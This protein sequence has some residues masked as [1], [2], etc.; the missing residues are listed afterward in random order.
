M[1][2]YLPKSTSFVPAG[3]DLGVKLLTRVLQRLKLVAN[4][5]ICDFPIRENTK[6]IL[7]LWFATG[8]RKSQIQVS[9][10]VGIVFVSKTTG[11][12]S[13]LFRPSTLMKT[14]WSIPWTTSRILYRETV[15]VCTTPS[16]TLNDVCCWQRHPHGPCAAWRVTSARPRQTSCCTWNEAMRGHFSPV[17]FF[18]DGTSSSVAIFWYY[19]AF[20][21]L[22]GRKSQITNLCLWITNTNEIWECSTIPSPL[23]VSGEAPIGLS[24]K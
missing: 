4:H 12:A 8:G 13:F 23:N 1:S 16:C 11:D 7:D 19:F 18:G 22:S 15:H 17:A 6:Y 5:K 20:P 10:C 14:T 9:T 3:T 21:H 2:T 24:N